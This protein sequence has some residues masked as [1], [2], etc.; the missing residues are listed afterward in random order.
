MPRIEPE[1]VDPVTREQFKA[2]LDD[3]MWRLNNLYYI[4]TKGEEDDD[5]LVVKFKPNRAQR[6]L[7]RRLH[8]RNIILKARQLGF[9]TLIAI[10]WL[11]TALFSKSPIRC[12]IVAQDRDTAEVIFRDKVKF[13]YERLPEFLRKEMP[14]ATENKSELLWAHNGSSI[15]VATSY[16]G[17][18]PHRLHISEFGKIAAANPAKAREVVTGSLPA[19]PKNGIAVIESTA[20]GQ[21]GPFYDMSMRALALQESGGKLSQKDYRMHFF[22]WWEDPGYVLDAADVYFTE[23]NLEYFHQVE[24]KI[25]RPLSDEQRAWY[26]MT[27]RADFSDEAPLMWQEY[28]SFPQEA[29]QVS[30]EGCYYATQ[31]AT[32]R[33]QG[34]ILPTLPIESAPVNT[35]W[36]IGRGDMTSIWLHQRIGAWNHFIGYYEASGEEL[37]HYTEYLQKK[38]FTFGAHYLPHEAAYKRIGKNADTNQSI[39]EMLEELMPGQT[40]HVVPRISAITAGIQA[41]R[42]QFASCRFSEE[43]CGVGITKR[44]PN[45]RK[46]WDKTRMCWS[47]NP[48]HNDD[49]HGADAFRQFGQA[50]TSGEQFLSAIKPV[51]L[52]GTQAVRRRGSAMAV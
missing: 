45:Y 44:L 20:E 16:R 41:T 5:E 14:L 49:S 36:D 29:F 18:T 51:R 2:H 52:P 15:R 7:I 6:R 31:L 9:T 25:G 22:A 43:G 47:A 17:G 23:A 39:Q 4:I 50:A 24:G 21:D 34:R 3:V 11:D 10:L 19:V 33:K 46:T 1:V 30:T 37:D 42:A 26:V 12:G 28:P 48:V 32:A 13:A 27:L 35:F 38:G 8:H 40:F